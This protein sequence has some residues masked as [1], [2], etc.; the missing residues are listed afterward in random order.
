MS[1]MWIQSMWSSKRLWYL[2]HDFGFFSTSCSILSSLVSCRQLWWS[3]FKVMTMTWKSNYNQ[4]TSWSIV[5]YTIHIAFHVLHHSTRMLDQLLD[6]AHMH[7]LNAN[8]SSAQIAISLSMKS[9]TIVQVVGVLV[10]KTAIQ[11]RN[12]RI[13]P[14]TPFIHS[15]FIQSIHP[16]H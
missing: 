11:T 6:Q 4:F 13:K 14:N 1:T 3:P 5:H 8:T 15:T 2:W 16:T 12:K 9:F 10:P 7:V